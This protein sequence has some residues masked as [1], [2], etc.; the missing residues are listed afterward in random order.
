[1]STEILLQAKNK[2]IN[3]H[4]TLRTKYERWD[5][6]DSALRS[7]L[8][9]VQLLESV[10]HAFTHRRCALYEDLSFISISACCRQLPAPNA[11]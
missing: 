8:V 7:Q 2:S 4:A 1:M 3:S 9:Q 6:G 11:C 5:L 10:R